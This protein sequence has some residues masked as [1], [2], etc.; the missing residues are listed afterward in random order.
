MAIH[1]V[2]RADPSDPD[3]Q[4]TPDIYFDKEFKVID[5]NLIEMS[6]N[7]SDVVVLRQDPTERELLAKHLSITLQ[8]NSDLD[9]III[10]N[11][12]DHLQ[13]IFLYDI[14]LKPGAILNM[15]VFV[16]DGKLNK[17][18]FQVFLEDRA[19]FSLYGLVSNQ[20]GGDSEVVVKVVHGGAYSSS[21]QTFLGMAGDHSQTVFQGAVMTNTAAEGSHISLCSSNLIVGPGGKCCAKPE[22][23][24]N[25]EYCNSEQGSDTSTI[26][27]EKVGYLQSK[28]IT[29]AQARK[30]IITGFQNQVFDL[31]D[32]EN[33]Q[34]EVRNMYSS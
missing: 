32:D 33:I 13:Q 31:I 18:I 26:S 23:Y 30:M 19:M 28:G 14:H 29:E 12:D 27:L 20:T 17:H 11:A 5:A 15:G 25:S 10:N 4:F 21:F 9:L 3:W 24:I 2:L 6:E 22:T 34:S 7:E 8:R 1:S 16:K